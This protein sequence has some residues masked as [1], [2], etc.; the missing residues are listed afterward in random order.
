M[1]FGLVLL[2]FIVY[3]CSWK[4]LFFSKQLRKVLFIYYIKTSSSYRNLEEHIDRRV[5]KIYLITLSIILLLTLTKMIIYI[6]LFI[7]KLNKQKKKEERRRE[8]PKK[9]R[10]IDWKC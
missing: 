7:S 5:S 6:Y 9:E 2:L 8:K 4:E 1:L 3:L 10:T